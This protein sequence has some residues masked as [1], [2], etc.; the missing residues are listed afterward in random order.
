MLMGT[1][2]ATCDIN[3]NVYCDIKCYMWHQVLMLTSIANGDIKMLML[4]LGDN[5][6]MK[7]WL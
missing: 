6:N 1:W 4:T 3:I 2:K 7:C 5:G